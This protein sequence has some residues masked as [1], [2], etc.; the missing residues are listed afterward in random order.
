L[1]Y[2]YEPFAYSVLVK[3]LRCLDRVFVNM[4]NKPSLPLT[5][6]NPLFSLVYICTCL[7]VCVCARARIR[8]G[9]QFSVAFRYKS[10]LDPRILSPF[11]F[12]CDFS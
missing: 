2:K 3:Y 9:L 10:V 11:A 1:L 12:S 4:Q 7:C 5:V 6:V 8:R